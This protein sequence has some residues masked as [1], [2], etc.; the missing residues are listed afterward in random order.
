VAGWFSD[1]FRLIWALVY[2]NSRK[3]Y[4]RL[5]R[6]RVPCPCQSIS[7]SGR[8]YES[9]CEACS[10]WERPARFRAVCPLLVSTPQGLRC[11]VNA[12]DVRPFWGRAAGLAGGGLATAYLLAT[13]GLFVGLRVIG[14]PVSYF[15]VAWPPA[16]SRINEAR[17]EYFLRKGV[18]ALAENNIKEALLSL[19]YAYTIAPNNYDVGFALASLRQLANPSFSDQLYARLLAQHPAHNDQTADAWHRALLARGDYEQLIRLDLAQLIGPGRDHIGYWMQSLLFAARQTGDA[20]PLRQLLVDHPELAPQW[21]KVLETAMLV[22]TGHANQAVPLLRQAWPEA[23]HPFVPF[24]Q[25][26]TLIEL[27]APQAALALVDAYGARVRDDE[28]YRLRLDAYAALGWQSVRAND[29]DLLLAGTPS[30]AVIE[31]IGAHLVRYPNQALLD[32]VFVRLQESPLA[33]TKENHHAFA[34]LFCAAGAVGDISKMHA[35]VTSL[36]RI[37]G[38][39][40]VSLTAFED[41]FSESGR[42]R[43]AIET[44]VP[45]LPLPIDVTYALLARYSAPRQA[46]GI[47]QR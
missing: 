4:F 25:A 41:F 11:S 13:I 2:W 32:R 8:A 20:S 17:G 23:S 15:A 39:Y 6:G 27:G 46:V 30:P 37:T 14:Y 19:S 44:L 38:T 34:T 45:S 35:M 28:R 1:F 33:L 29:V 36:K 7:D 21:K 24:Y 22:R 9:M 3:T 26:D 40:F 47:A 10:L 16:W 12:Q 43:R 31:L 5:R 18:T 42:H